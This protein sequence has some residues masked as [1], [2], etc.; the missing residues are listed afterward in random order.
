MTKPLRHIRTPN[1]Q[2]WCC[3]NCDGL[4]STFKKRTRMAAEK[5]EYREARN[6]LFVKKEKENES[7]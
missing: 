4:Y 1:K 3:V 5:H 6:Y 2:G 7:A